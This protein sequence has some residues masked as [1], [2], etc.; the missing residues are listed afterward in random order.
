MVVTPLNTTYHDEWVVHELPPNPQGLVALQ[1]L[2]ILEGFNF[3]DDGGG[4][5]F[6]KADYLHVMV[7]AKKLA[8]ADAAAF[9]ADPSFVDVPVE[10]LLSKAYAADRRKLI[11]MT[12]AALKVE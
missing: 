5:A 12:M 2:N 10:G 8:F 1:M 6:N 9:Y 7:E 4:F 3:S 11:N